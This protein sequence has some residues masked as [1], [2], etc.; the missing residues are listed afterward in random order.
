MSNWRN[1]LIFNCFKKRDR[2]PRNTEPLQLPKERK[3]RLRILLLPGHREGDGART[4]QTHIEESEW[5]REVVAK[6]ELKYGGKHT[7]VKGCEWRT[8]KDYGAY[9]KRVKK[10]CKEHEV[11]ICI[12]VHLNASG[13]PEARGCEMLVAENDETARMAFTLI[14]FFSIRFQVVPRGWYKTLQGVRARGHSDRGGYFLNVLNK[15]GVHAMIFEPF[16]CDYKSRESEQFLE[17]PDYGVDKV[18]NYFVKA[19]GML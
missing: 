19:L 8:E 2:E 15:A 3:E 13:I 16:F 10:F 14:S 18:S 12:E 9:V 4:Y 6:V 1:I 7:I 17:M 11:D 5:N